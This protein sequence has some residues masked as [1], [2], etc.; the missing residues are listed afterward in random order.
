M[1][2]IKRQAEKIL[3]EMSESFPVVLVTGARQVGKSTLLKNEKKS[4]PYITFDEID[5]MESAI[6]DPKLFLE[7]NMPPVILDEVQYVPNLF[8][9]IKVQVDRQNKAGLYFL[10]GSQKF[11]LMKNVSESLAGRIGIL[12]LNGISL[13]EMLNDNFSKPFLPNEDFIKNRIKSSKKCTAKDVWRIIQEGSFPAVVSKKNKWS[14]F[15]AS[16]I[17]TYIERDV[18]NLTQIGDELQFI[19]FITIAAS[20]TGQLLNY[21]DLAKETGISEPTAKKWLSILIT[22]GLVY[23]LKPYSTNVE[24]RVVKTPKLYFLDTG[25]VCWLTKWTSSEVLESGAMAGAIFETFVVSEIV[26]SYTNCGL[27]PPIYFYRDRDKKEIDIVIE[28]NGTL[29]PVEIKK[30]TNPKK[31][32]ASSFQCL[33]TLKNME[34]GNGTIICMN[35]S[36]GILDKNLLSIPYTFI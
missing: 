5:K 26:K 22:S 15:Y 24:K 2:Y 8:R 20:R 3:N 19:Q 17:K 27:E 35:D 16:Y 31:S 30:S 6:N 29:Y 18:R 10:T 12:E 23:L 28:N 36:V 32:D 21:A 11:N 33:S 14:S 4:L 25:L 34:V 7:M 9:S 13:R 1:D